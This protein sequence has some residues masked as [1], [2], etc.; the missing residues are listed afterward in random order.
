MSTYEITHLSGIREL[1][2]FPLKEALSRTDIRERRHPLNRCPDG[3]RHH[4]RYTGKKQTGSLF[5]R[6]WPNRER[7][8]ARCGKKEW[9]W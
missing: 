6:W 7:V 8:C 2:A 5:G 4:F 9:V 1:S 3:S